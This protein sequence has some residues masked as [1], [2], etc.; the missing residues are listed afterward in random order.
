VVA[1]SSAGWQGRT[2]PLWFRLGFPF[3]YAADLLQNLEALVAVGSA[4]DARLGN[5]IDFIVSR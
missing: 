4:R 1:H 3:G 5:A 2:S